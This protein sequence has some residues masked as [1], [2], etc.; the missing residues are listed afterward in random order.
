MQTYSDNQLVLDNCTI[1]GFK[2]FFII[3]VT[4][5]T[6]L[7]SGGIIKCISLLETKHSTGNCK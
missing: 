5:S 6:K 4:M 7:I 3:Q 1:E 2:H